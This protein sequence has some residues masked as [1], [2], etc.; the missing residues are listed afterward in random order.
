M[1]FLQVKKQYSVIKSQTAQIQDQAAKIRDQDT[2]IADL[3][4]HVE[5]WDSK[6][7]DLSSRLNRSSRNGPTAI[8]KSSTPV[9]PL[10]E[11]PSTSSRFFTSNIKPRKAQI[12]PHLDLGKYEP[13]RKRKSPCLSL[14]ASSSVIP[15]KISRLDY[16]LNGDKKNNTTQFD[17]DADLSVLNPELRLKVRPKAKQSYSEM[18]LKRRPSFLSQSLETLLNKA[19]V[20]IESRKRKLP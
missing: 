10:V 14:S 1:Y 12:L 6:L 3:K 9:S 17:Y 5:E 16:Y 4:R 13:E 8:G 11:T 18:V 20:S 7:Q 2:S 19:A 15:N